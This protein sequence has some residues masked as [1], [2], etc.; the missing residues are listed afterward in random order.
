[1]G[2]QQ[3]SKRFI[4]CESDKK[5]RTI[6]GIKYVYYEE[7]PKLKKKIKPLNNIDNSEFYKMDNCILAV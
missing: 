3:S 5:Y 6:H 1:M 4:Y 7:R 2:N